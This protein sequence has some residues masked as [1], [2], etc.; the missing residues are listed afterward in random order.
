MPAIKFKVTPQDSDALENIMKRGA[1]MYERLRGGKCDRLSL[2]MDLTACHANGMPL[3][4]DELAK[5]EDFDFAHDVFG[6]Q[7]HIDRNTGKLTDCFVPRFH[8]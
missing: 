2:L 1:A 7:R 3:K 6:I 8:A 5:A 4:L